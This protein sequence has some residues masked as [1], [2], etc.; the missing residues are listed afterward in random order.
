[1]IG[2][3]YFEKIIDKIEF[4]SEN[5]FSFDIDKKFRLKNTQVKS[6]VKLN[7]LVFVDKLGLKEV[8]PNTDKKMI[9][10]NHNIKVSYNDKELI[11]DGTGNIS[12]EKDDKIKYK[13]T[14]SKKDIKFNTTLEILNNIF[15]LEFISYEKKDKSNLKINI[16]GKK[17]LKG[18]I[19]FKK[20]PS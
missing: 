6:D 20:F 7:N 2:T 14:K 5:L 1:M 13:I 16:K 8:F 3:N 19:F 12:L 4:Q 9:L 18:N 10:K 17:D 15:K 11:L